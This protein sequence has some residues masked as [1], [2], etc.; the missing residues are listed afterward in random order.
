MDSGT[1]FIAQM[2]SST[3]SGIGF[4]L[5]SLLEFFLTIFLFTIIILVF[6]ALFKK[7]GYKISR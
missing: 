1:I 2:V 7:M 6:A 3:G 5:P 4:V